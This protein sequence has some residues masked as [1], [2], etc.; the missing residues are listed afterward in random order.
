MARVVGALADELDDPEKLL[1]SAERAKNTRD[2]LPIVRRS[3]LPRMFDVVVA[4][5]DRPMELANLL[6]VLGRA[7]INVRDVE[8]L[9]IRETGGEA[10]RVGVGNAEDQERAR[11]ALRAAGYGAR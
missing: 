2:A 10:I 11:E 5:P 6:G 1:S 8:V 3:M 7:A 4:I 9:K